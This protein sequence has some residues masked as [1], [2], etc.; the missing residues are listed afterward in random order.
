MWTRKEIKERG[1]I[2]FKKNYWKGIIVAVLL[3]LVAGGAYGGFSGGSA[4]SR[5]RRNYSNSQEGHYVID[6]NEDGSKFTVDV[7]ED[8]DGETSYEFG[9]EDKDGNKLEMEDVKPA[10]GNDKYDTIAS[11]IFVTIMVLIGAGLVCAV[12]LAIDAFVINPIE[13][14]CNK[15]FLDNLEKEAD[16]ST[17]AYAFDHN[18]KNVAKVMFRRDLSI[19]LWSLLLIIPGIYKTYEYRM[20]SY[21]LAENPDMT[22]E[23]ASA[24]SREMMNGNKWRAFVLDLSFIGWHIL[25]IFTL[26]LLEVFYVNPYQFSTNAALYEA[27]KYGNADNNEV[28]EA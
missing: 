8:K 9:A 23:E 13:M 26:G 22:W 12:I 18:Y 4:A 28:V 6:E 19:F 1:K 7:K 21:I 14:G 16:V 15:F 10:F 20:I 5:Y 3:S 2:S 17:V 24:E 25:A 11:A 27:I